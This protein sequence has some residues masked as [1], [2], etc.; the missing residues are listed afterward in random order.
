[1][2][3]HNGF[4]TAALALVLALSALATW[5]ASPAWAADP[6]TPEAEAEA[7]TLYKDAKVSY[8][9][10]KFAEALDKLER[11]YALYP[12]PIIQFNLAQVHKAMGHLKD[13]R[14]LY[15]RYADALK[16]ELAG[17]TKKK[18]HAALEAKLAGVEATITG[19]EEDIAAGKDHSAEPPK[20]V[21][22]P[23]ATAPAVD[24]HLLAPSKPPGADAPPPPPP[25]PVPWGKYFGVGGAALGGAAIVAV[26]VTLLIV[27][28]GF[29]SLPNAAYTLYPYR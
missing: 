11:A 16:K 26:A 21:T 3:R 20:D 4:E 2:R 13:A 14:F 24:M 1:M 22:P 8:D 12:T 15:V 25:K 17:T 27:Q 28:P 5:G 18:E 7:R 10:G 19:L 23:P 6:G 9:L 29:V